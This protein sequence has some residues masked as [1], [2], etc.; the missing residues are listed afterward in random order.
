[1]T[2]TSMMYM[3]MVLLLLSG[4]AAPVPSATATPAP[5][6]T[7]APVLATSAD[8]VLGLWQL[9]SGD[10]AI[11]FQFDEDG[12]YRTAQ[13]VVTNLQDSPQQLGQFTLEDGLLTLIPSEESPYCAGESGTYDVHLLEGGRISFLQHE[14][15]C[16]IRTEYWMASE[17]E[18]LS[19]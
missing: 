8:D 5:T 7:P 17:L 3:V 18:P 6:E 12:T 14:D 2:K 15:P 9:G 19:P 10:F 11:F 4:C 16:T 1:M 13:R